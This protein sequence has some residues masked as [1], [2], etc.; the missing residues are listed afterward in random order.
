M[1]LV[2]GRE[3]GVG[4]R[5]LESESFLI[6]EYFHPS[7]EPFL[8]EESYRGEPV[9]GRFHPAPAGRRHVLIGENID[10]PGSLVTNFPVSEPAPSSDIAYCRW[11]PEIFGDVAQTLT[12]LI[13]EIERRN[14][15]EDPDDLPPEQWDRSGA[16]TA[17]VNLRDGISEERV[18][19]IRHALSARRRQEFDERAVGESISRLREMVWCDGAEPQFSYTDIEHDLWGPGVPRIRAAATFPQGSGLPAREAIVGVVKENTVWRVDFL[20][21]A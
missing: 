20:S 5:W 15:E 7:D 13:E 4:K 19:K 10:L 11:E 8:N 3:L 21:W 17:L 2:S 9:R 12:Q 18:P 6:G 1:V 14:A 16:S